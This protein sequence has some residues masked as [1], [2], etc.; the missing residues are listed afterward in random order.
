MLKKGKRWT[1]DQQTYDFFLACDASGQKR[2]LSIF[3]GKFKFIE[4][5]KIYEFQFAKLGNNGL[6][7]SAGYNSFCHPVQD[8]II[9]DIFK[10]FNIFDEIVVGQIDGLGGFSKFSACENCQGGVKENDAFCT[11]CKKKSPKGAETFR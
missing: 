4:E 9:E 10:D 2:Y 3:Q 7:F 1:K 6:S 8:P 11:H 5:Q